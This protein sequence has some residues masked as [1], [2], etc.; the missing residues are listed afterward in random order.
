MNR[1]WLPFLLAV[2][3]LTVAPAFSASGLSPFFDPQT[4]LST[5]R[6]QR[7]MTGTLKTVYQGTTIV[8]NRVEI[9]GVVQRFNLGEDIILGKMLDG[10][11]VEKKIGVI[12]GMSGSPVYVQGK[13]IGALAFSWPFM[14]EPIFGITSINSMLKAWDRA[15]GAEQQAP[16]Q[17]RIDYGV[18]LAGR[19]VTR[20]EVSWTPTA[21][22]LDER[23]IA[24]Q[25]AVPLLSC[26]GFSG[27]ALKGL[28]QF[29]QPWGLTPLAGPGAVRDPVDVRL[30]PGAAVG[31]QLVSGDFDISGV[32]TVTYVHDGRVLAFGHQLLKLGGVDFPL[33]TAWI[34]GIL[35]TLDHSTKMGSAMKPV[36]ALRQDTPWAIG[37]QLGAQSP[38]VP[39]Q[40]RVTN[41]DSGL[42]QVYNFQV[43]QHDSLTPMLLVMGVV[44][45][46]DAAYSPGACGTLTTDFVMEGTKG[47][48]AARA[49]TA[50]F[51]GPPVNEIARSLLE[52]AALFRYNLWDPQSVKSLRLEAT[53]TNRDQ[54]ALIERIYSEQ[55]IAKAG[56]PLAVHVV[57]RPWGG[58]P[59]D[60]RLVLPLP[61][62]LPATN[63]QI[64]AAGGAL[65]ASLRSHLGVLTPDYDNL[66]DMLQEFARAEDNTQLVVLA[67]GTQQG[68]AVGATRLPR[69]PQSVQDLLGAA[70]PL[71]L[72]QGYEE[73]G[74][75]KSEPWV[76]FGGA[77]L[78]VPVESRTGERPSSHPGGEDGS[79]PDAGEDSEAPPP[80]PPA[81]VKDLVWPAKP[82]G[83][84]EFA[85]PEYPPASLAWAARGLRAD[86][87]A[88][89]RTRRRTDGPEPPTSAGVK[90]TKPG[91]ASPETKKTTRGRPK[92]EAKKETSPKEGEAKKTEEGVGLVLRQPSSFIH[93]TADDF[94]EGLT[95]STGLADE[96]GVLLVP[97]WQRLAALSDRILFAATCAPDG[98]LY[99]S[100]DGGRVY[101]LQGD[102]LEL[103]CE[104][105]EFAV[106]ALAVRNDAS[107]LAGCS[108]SGKILRLSPQGQATPVA[109]IPA[110]YLW[111]F[112]PAPDGSVYVGTGPRAV[113]YRLTADEVCTPLTTLP[114]GHILALAWRGEELIAATAQEGQIYVVSKGGAARAVFGST[115]DDLTS[116]AVDPA[117]NIYTGSVPSGQVTRISPSDEVK[118]VY[119]DSDTPVYSLLATA[120][121]VYA[122][123]ASDGQIFL[124]RDAD[125]TSSVLLDSPADFISRLLATPDGR[126]YALGNGPGGVLSSS[127]TAAR[128]GTYLSPT[129]DASRL[130][131]WGRLAWEAQAPEGAVVVQ[132]RSGNTDDPEDG[133]W[134]AWTPPLSNN[135]RVNLPPARYAQYR[136]RL[137]AP[138]DQPVLVRRVSLSYLAANQPPTIEVSDPAAAA[139]VHG[140]VKISWSASDPD[141]DALLTTLFYRPAGGDWQQ[142]GDPT[143]DES[144]DWQTDSL[145][146]GRYDLRLVVSDAR[147]NPTD[148]LQTETFVRGLLVDNEAPALLAELT[149]APPPAQDAGGTVPAQRSDITGAALDEHS[150]IVSIAWKNAADDKGSDA[151]WTA[152]RLVGPLFG[153]PLVSF[154]IPHA[155]IPAGIERIIVRAI[156]AAGNYSDVEVDLTTGEVTPEE[157][158]APAAPPA[159]AQG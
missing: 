140:Q 15:A 137:Q 109:Q 72:S 132:C 43:V 90:E 64:G 147:S 45:A 81:P 154:A 117:G 5:D 130:A 86:I 44:S 47:A 126:V 123:T 152:A 78:T 58:R 13:L 12:A 35:P 143:K 93:A 26:S 83:R 39:V 30:E 6:V 40:V 141:D 133:T 24:L 150:G 75:S 65:A 50:Y 28:G 2:G 113:L 66:Q 108:P 112:L 69:L 102:K 146:P 99:F 38:S 114:A 37:G 4:M 36:G 110:L 60:E 156:D 17:A 14:T 22:F 61:A 52:A 155:Q 80:A 73:I 59:V 27:E 48:R 76:L 144:Y 41:A 16:T 118:T 34:H 20:A 159:P 21:P 104:T 67:A 18:Q 89:V 136:L 32:G 135:S 148:A 106:T 91:E 122:G 115:G 19:T 138:A 31:V 124:I 10:P 129:L 120:D 53:L 96:G 105:G 23:T 77:L 119:D 153:A 125:R 158:S 139:A 70:V 157:H 131:T 92:P 88:Q 71:Y 145:S 142:L 100:A 57:I 54:T 74:V 128:E 62:D 84:T 42:R 56:E 1:L 79:P 9:L 116:L 85:L 87:A 121:G 101:R 7:G 63:L 3:L 111:A 97:T 95:R 94:K 82:L 107:L 134:S 29:F 68:M 103:F 8:E 98:T 51:E 151:K 127:L 46:L 11:V 25:P 33:T 149:P 55:A 49:N